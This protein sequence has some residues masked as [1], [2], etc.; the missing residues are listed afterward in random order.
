MNQYYNYNN[1]AYVPVYDPER[2][3]AL[4]KAQQKKNMRS[5]CNKIGFFTTV[6]MLTMYAAAIILTILTSIGIIPNTTET[7][8]LVQIIYPVASSLIPVLIFMAAMK[9]KVSNVLT[10]TL[11]K[12]ATLISVIMFGMG[13]AMIANIA[14]VL[15]DNN[16]SLFQL[17]NY[18]NPE[19][20]STDL[21]SFLMNIIS[22][23]L[24]P[25]FAEELAYRGFVL[26]QLRKYGDAFAIF[27]SALLF[28]AMHGN[29]TQMVFA[30]ILGLVF[31]FVDVKT[32]S[33]IPSVIIHFINNF[34]AI[35][36]DLLA[37]D[38]NLTDQQ[39]NLFYFGIMAAFCII[40]LLSAVYLARTDKQFF[41]LNDKTKFS[42]LLEFKEKLSAFFFNPGVIIALSLFFSEMIAN[43]IPPEAFGGI[44]SQ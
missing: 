8:N 42:S 35:V 14:A 36:A 24:V 2:E 29:T 28:G 33:I 27:G 37:S 10:K 15:F 1:Y 5:L 43:M 20:Q 3:K 41:S 40:G 34:Y 19:P 26:N 11:V 32:N 44:I 4:Q 21:P 18:G 13:V 30:F 23:A 31:A 16:I 12:P 9:D 38:T 25:A 17:H 6:Y 7:S 39:T 22:V